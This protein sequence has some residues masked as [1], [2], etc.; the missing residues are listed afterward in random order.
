MAVNKLSVRDQKEVL[1][2]LECRG[3]AI[4]PCIPDASCTNRETAEANYNRNV[5]RKTEGFL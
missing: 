1:S 4:I 2:N 5:N 3:S